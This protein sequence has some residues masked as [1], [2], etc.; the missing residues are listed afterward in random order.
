MKA[1][2]T[3]GGGFLGRALVE[4]LCVA[5]HEVTAASRGHYPELAALGARGLR[6]DIGDAPAVRA[7]VRG[8]DVVFHVAAR[9]GVWGPR[10]EFIRTNVDGTR[11]VIEACRAEAVPRLVYT[12]SPSVA[13]DGGNHEN[14]GSDLP[15][16]S[17]F[18]C[19]YP[20]TKAQAERLVLAANGPALA[21]I[22][23]RPHLIWGPRDPHLLPRL[24]A[25][26]EAGRLRIV[27]DGR[28]K[29]GITYVDNA[30]AAH[31]QAADALAPGA[32]GA[33]RA[34]FLHDAEPVE[35]WPWLNGLLARLGIS[36]ATRRVPLGVARAAGS[37]AEAVWSLFRLAGEPPVTRF[38]AAQLAR[39]HWYDMTPARDA[40]GYRP[41]VEPAEA[42]EA[43]IRWW[44]AA[45][46]GRGQ[47][48][49]PP[50]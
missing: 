8:H 1:L 34:F 33:G 11:H 19:A 22:A 17:S 37:V 31:V 18:E 39:S 46:R 12:S 50:R 49:T 45:R 48:R 28:N 14:G 41:V 3:G 44:T 36:A 6:L 40:F 35:L 20:E 5:G 10:D 27:G 32:A 2:V 47:P 15:Y 23:L 21:T 26:A 38:V 42:L 43:T 16:A 4:R 25:R 7:A 29:V 13:F 9:A 24:I 30:A